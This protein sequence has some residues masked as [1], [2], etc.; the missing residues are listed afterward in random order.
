M[1]RG[2][3][4]GLRPAS[5]SGTGPWPARVGGTG[6][7]RRNGDL[8]ANSVRTCGR[9]GA[10]ALRPGVSTYSLPCRSPP[11]VRVFPAPIPGGA[12]GPKAQGGGSSVPAGTAKGSGSRDCASWQPPA[13]QAPT[14]RSDSTATTTSTEGVTW[15][16]SRCSVPWTRTSIDLARARAAFV[17]GHGPQ[18]VAERRRPG[19]GVD[20]DATG[21]GHQVPPRRSAP[22]ATGSHSCSSSARPNSWR[23]PARPGRYR[24]PSP[25]TRPWQVDGRCSGTGPWPDGVAGQAPLAP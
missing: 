16:C 7:L 24:E 12:L 23:H 11:M 13:A 9:R 1:R 22:A 4:D 2:P 8:F 14:D 20:P 6:A 10:G 25:G 21:G 15:I 19:P 5:W 17:A 18:V 3:A